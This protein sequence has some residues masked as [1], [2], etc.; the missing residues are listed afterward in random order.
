MPQVRAAKGSAAI[1]NAIMLDF[2]HGRNLSHAWGETQKHCNIRQTFHVT[3][4]AVRLLLSRC[5]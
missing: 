4:A 5:K 1:M 2:K 3:L